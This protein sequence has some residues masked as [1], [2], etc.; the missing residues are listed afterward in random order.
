MPSFMS[1]DPNMVFEDGSDS[2]S[3]VQ[4]NQDTLSFEIQT[5]DEELV[6][7][8]RTVLRQCDI[9]DRLHE[10]NLS[11][12]VLSNTYPDFVTEPETAFTVALFDIYEY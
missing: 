8:Q 10:L 12:E 2:S 9:L 6:G 7:V 11:I 1:G 4:F 3:L 5:D